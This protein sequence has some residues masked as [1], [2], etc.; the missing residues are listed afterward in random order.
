MLT[1]KR[2]NRHVLVRTW[3]KAVFQH[4]WFCYTQWQLHVS[5]RVMPIFLYL[6][7]ISSIRDCIGVTTCMF[8]EYLCMT[9]LVKSVKLIGEMLTEKMLKTITFIL[10]TFHKN[11]R[12]TE[13]I[14]L[15]LTPIYLCHKRLHVTGYTC[16]NRSCFRR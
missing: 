1:E 6:W 14:K 8:M 9:L 5:Q 4:A 10:I 12:N 3:T 11:H 7:T 16:S 15:A 13:V 2:Q